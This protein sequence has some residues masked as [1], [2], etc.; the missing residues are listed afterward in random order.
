MSIFIEEEFGRSPT[1]KQP[2]LKIPEIFG[3]RPY[4]GHRNP[5]TRSQIARRVSTTFA[6]RGY[7][8]HP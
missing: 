8:L 4:S 1:G 5:L 3:V 2:A 6:L 7:E